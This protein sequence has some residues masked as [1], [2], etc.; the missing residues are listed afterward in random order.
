M[1][2]G[3]IPVAE[4]EGA[5]LAHSVK[6]AEGVFKKGRLL[7]ARD[8]ELLRLSG[9]SAVFAAWLDADDVP[10]DEAAAAVAKAIAGENTAAQAP[11]TGRANLHADIRGVAVIEAERVRALNRLHESLTL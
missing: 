9:V 2:F 1:R 8:I 7:S 4:S 10:E 5:I 11:F 6:H 3:E